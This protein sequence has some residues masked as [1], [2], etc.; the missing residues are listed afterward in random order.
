VVHQELPQQVAPCVGRQPRLQLLSPNGLQSGRRPQKLSQT[1]FAPVVV[2][3]E[4]PQQV[5]LCVGRQPRLRLLSPN[6]LQLGS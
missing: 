6:G 5:V 1:C 3:R 4:L 2:H